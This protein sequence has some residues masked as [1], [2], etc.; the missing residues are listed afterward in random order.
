MLSHRRTPTITTTTSKA[1]KEIFDGR[2]A[3]ECSDD[4]CVPHRCGSDG[5]ELTEQIHQSIELR[6][7]AGDGP[8]EQ[9]HQHDSTEEGDNSPHAIP[10]GEEAHRSGRSYCQS[11]AA[12]E[13]NISKREKRRVKEEEHPQ[14][15][16]HAP[17]KK[18]TCAY[19]RVVT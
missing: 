9:Y 6:T 1:L 8:T 17:Q 19:L 7:H 2:E 10:S 4:R 16:K 12:E 5:E 3:E 14:K 15:Q 13:E 18:E 11:E